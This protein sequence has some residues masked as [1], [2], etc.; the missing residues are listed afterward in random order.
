[1]ISPDLYFDAK[2]YENE[3]ILMSIFEIRTRIAIQLQWDE[4]EGWRHIIALHD[5]FAIS[6][7]L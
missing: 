4:D 2:S 7:S 3:Y 5:R 1:M 6:W